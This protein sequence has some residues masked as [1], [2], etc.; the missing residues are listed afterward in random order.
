[1]VTTVGAEPRGSALKDRSQDHLAHVYPGV[2]C[3][4]G[5]GGLR[6]YVSSHRDP[7]HLHRL[8]F[9]SDTPPM[10]YVFP[11]VGSTSYTMCPVSLRVQDLFWG[12]TNGRT[13]ETSVVGTPEFRGKL[14]HRDLFSERK[15]RG[16]HFT[17]SL[18]P[19]LVIFSFA[20]S[21]EVGS[22]SC[23]TRESSTPEGRKDWGVRLVKFR[24]IYE[25]NYLFPNP[26]YYPPLSE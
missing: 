1:M 26:R 5:E 9:E 8:L 21:S 13:V 7:Y 3:S 15:G 10:W 4:P 18:P 11:V 23:V 19:T 16:R 22:Q 17:P 25:V 24:L 2:E 12:Y 20:S 14:S 6:V